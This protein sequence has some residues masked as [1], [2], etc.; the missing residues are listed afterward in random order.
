MYAVPTRPS[1]YCEDESS[2]P[3]GKYELGIRKPRSNLLVK[4]RKSSISPKLVPPGSVST[5][6]PR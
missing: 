6:D 3:V 5:F 2:A 1:L 4:Y